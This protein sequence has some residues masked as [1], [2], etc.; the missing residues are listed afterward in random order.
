M[1]TIERDNYTT[2]TIVQ[3]CYNA[4][5]PLRIYRDVFRSKASDRK[6]AVIKCVGVTAPTN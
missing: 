2:Q 3:H 4:P 1:I 5:P 6:V